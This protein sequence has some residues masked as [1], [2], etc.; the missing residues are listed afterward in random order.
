MTSSF[1]ME[2]L[3]GHE[4]LSTGEHFMGT[5][6]IHKLLFAKKLYTTE[7]NVYLL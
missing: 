2:T 1:H 5:L 4:K 6:D 3:W 7:L